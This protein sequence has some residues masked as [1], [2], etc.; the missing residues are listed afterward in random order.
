MDLRFEDHLAVEAGRTS[1]G[2]RFHDLPSTLTIGVGAP[3]SD[4][5]TTV[6]VPHTPADSGRVE[7]TLSPDGRELTLAAT[8]IQLPAT[9]YVFVGSVGSSSP[10]GRHRQRAGGGAGL[11]RRRWRWRR[12]GG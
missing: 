1:I 9:L 3:I 12:R 2:Q 11:R 5:V 6:L 4:Q 7:I 10:G 8:H